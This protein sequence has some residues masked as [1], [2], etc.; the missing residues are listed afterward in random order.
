MR[1]SDR[2]GLWPPAPLNRV[3][4]H[5]LNTVRN[6]RI[7]KSLIM[8]AFLLRKFQELVGGLSVRIAQV[9][10]SFVHDDTILTLTTASTPDPFLVH[11]GDNYYFVR[12]Q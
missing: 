12:S 9:A 11:S 7:L 6:R 2:L 1:W 8:A 10:P 3:F 5:S 4:K